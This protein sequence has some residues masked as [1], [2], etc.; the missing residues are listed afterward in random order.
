MFSSREAR[1]IHN[2]HILPPLA[3]A[4]PSV[5]FHSRFGF[6]PFSAFCP[7][8]PICGRVWDQIQLL[9]LNKHTPTSVWSE[10]MSTDKREW[11]LHPESEYRFELDPGTSLAIKVRI[12]PHQGT[13]VHLT[14]ITLKLVRGTA[15]IFGAEL[16]QGKAYLFG[17]ECKAA[18]FTWEGCTLEISPFLVS[19]VCLIPK[20]RY[21]PAFHRLCI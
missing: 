5:P 3:G 14:D 8:T 15:E 16:V 9:S 2:D 4:R 1:S 10:R 20:A 21:W 19:Q 11:V 18:I 6:C 13:F 17:F 12:T 7:H